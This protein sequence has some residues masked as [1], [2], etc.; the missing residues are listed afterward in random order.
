MDFCAKKRNAIFLRD[1]R[2]TYRKSLFLIWDDTMVNNIASNNTLNNIPKIIHLT[3][4]LRVFSCQVTRRPIDYS[5]SIPLSCRRE[6]PGDRRGSPG[7][8]GGAPGAGGGAGGAAPLLGGGHT[9]PH[10]GGGG[11]RSYLFSCNK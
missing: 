7:G 1:A 4:D 8:G 3:P 10:Q 6:F 5:S 9:Q 2:S 11:R